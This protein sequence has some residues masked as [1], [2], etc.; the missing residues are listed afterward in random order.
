MLE[1]DMHEKVFTTDQVAKNANKLRTILNGPRPFYRDTV[2]RYADT[3]F[4][5]KSTQQY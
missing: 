2:H 4:V 1:D 5:Y 3:T